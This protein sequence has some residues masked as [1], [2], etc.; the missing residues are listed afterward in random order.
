M[1]KNNNTLSRVEDVEWYSGGSRY[2]CPKAVKI[3]G[4][5]QEVFSF[6]KLIIEDLT[7]RQRY[8][9]FRCHIGDN[10]F[11]DISPC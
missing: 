4:I 10:I 1:R 3:N 6:K 8:I 7:N 11:I 2:S 9:I 5:W